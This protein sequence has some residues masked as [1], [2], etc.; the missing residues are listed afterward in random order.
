MYTYKEAIKIIDSIELEFDIWGIKYENIQVWPIIR[1]ELVSVLYNI[2]NELKEAGSPVKQKD[3]KSMMADLFWIFKISWKEYILKRENIF[4]D[5]EKNIGKTFKADF[6]FYEISS[7][8]TIFNAKFFNRITD[9]FHMLLDGRGKI[10]H[11]ESV[12]YQF[13]FP[14]YNK[15]KLIDHLLVKHEFYYK[16]KKRLLNHETYIENLD[17][18]F[19]FLGNRN[20]SGLNKKLIIQCCE[21]L[22]AQSNYF[23]TLFRKVKPKLLFVD[24]YYH[25]KAMAAIYAAKSLKIPSI[26]LQHGLQG[27]NHQ[28]YSKWHKLNID[29]TDLLPD[30]FWVWDDDSYD[31][32]FT[33]SKMLNRHKPLLGGHPLITMIKN[34]DIQVDIP[35]FLLKQFDK[36]QKIILITLGSSPETDQFYLDVIKKTIEKCNLELFWIFRCHPDFITKNKE[37]LTKAFGNTFLDRTNINVHS[38][39]E[40]NLYGLLKHI[41]IHITFVSTV[42]IEAQLFGIKNIIMGPEGFDFYK[43]LIQTGQF[44]Y[45]DTVESL[46]EIIDEDKKGKNIKNQGLKTDME[47]ITKS[48]NCL[49]EIR[50]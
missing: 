30:Y 18:F 38:P 41:N 49:L 45:A 1:L 33:W 37:S 10:F 48:I 44:F 36:K 12:I 11:A 25:H 31:T 22:I 40:L 16:V 29:G 15:T 32:I 27:P 17:A 28:A 39:M 21:K 7:H 42:C 9:S 43:E 6:L 5:P 13:L 19:I 23:K 4:L 3:L 34:N 50:K 46:V 14:R 8:R 2:K 35:E 24:I 20:I 26:D 47:H